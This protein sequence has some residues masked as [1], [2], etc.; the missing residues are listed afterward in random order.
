VRGQSRSL[1]ATVLLLVLGAAEAVQ[2]LPTRV[3]AIIAYEAARSPGVPAEIGSP[4]VVG[5]PDNP[6]GEDRDDNVCEGAFDEDYDRTPRTIFDLLDLTNRNLI[7]GQGS[8]FWNPA[9]GPLGGYLLVTNPPPPQNAWQRGA[10]LYDQAVALYP[11]DRAGAYYRLGRVVHMLTD[12]ATPAHTHLDAHVSDALAGLLDTQTLSA[13]CFERY[14]AWHYVTRPDMPSDPDPAGRLRFE[15]DFVSAPIP[16]ATP[17]YLSD[18]GHPELGDAYKLF[19]SLARRSARWDS[20]NVSGTGPAG[21][22]GGSL[23]WTLKIDVA[24]GDPASIEVWHVDTAGRRT[25]IEPIATVGQARILLPDRSFA[26]ADRIE[27]VHDGTQTVLRA[28]LVERFSQ[29]ADADCRRMAEDLMPKAIAHTAALYRLFWRDTHPNDTIPNSVQIPG[30]V[31]EDGFVN[32]LDLFAV[33]NGFGL[34]PGDAGFDAR[35]DL[36]AS[37]LVDMG[38]LLIVV[39]HFGQAR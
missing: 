28:S 4:A 14:L 8:H 9:G 15:H 36:D 27:V 35:A 13:D 11:T 1:C 29:I 34:G 19:Y 31:D 33:V 30:D 10:M 6:I 18:G 25:R 7:W 23:R 2:A 38:D 17:A 21:V 39:D 16:P 3:H 5:S 26:A 24:F 20:N 37:G 22:G 12:M 32:I